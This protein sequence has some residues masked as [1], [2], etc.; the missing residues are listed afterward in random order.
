MSDASQSPVACGDLANKPFAH[1]VLYLYQRRS[2]GTLIV[3]SRGA[4][5]R[6]LFH[7]GQAVAA[8]V[9]Q[10]L[11]AL[12][13]SLLPLAELESAAFEFHAADLV[14]SGAD[15]VTGMFDPLAFAVRA[16]RIHA[17]EDI[18]VG[19]LS[20]YGSALLMLDPALNVG[21]L[22]L[23]AEELPF[24]HAC[25]AGPQ[26]CEALLR[27]AGMPAEEARRLLYSF[28]ITGALRP[29]SQSKRPSGS[30]PASSTPSSRSGPRRIESSVSTRPPGTRTSGDAWRAIASA[31][32]AMAEGRASDPGMG[33]PRGSGSA[34]PAPSKRVSTSL[35]PPRGASRSLS[36]PLPTNAHPRTAGPSSRPVSRPLSEPLPE[37]PMAARITESRPLSTR[38]RTSG[39]PRA[40]PSTP[41]RLTPRPS[42]SDLEGLD[43]SGKLQRIELL[44]QRNAF[45]EALP[46][47]RELLEEDRRNPKY[48][49]LLAHVLYGRV[50]DTNWGKELVDCVNMALRSDPDEPYALFTKARCYKRMGR[51][52]EAL[53]YFRRLLA[54]D[55][56]HMEAAREARLLASRLSDRRKK[57]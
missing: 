12:D 46:Y 26:S 18:V 13:D 29:E 20:K 54:I 44:C 25:R 53:H 23:T 31:A 34:K 43:A 57:G 24:L 3:R 4:E 52:R 30:L 2:S 19:V 17:R 38:E 27:Q 1:L 40:R 39:L 48:L 9:P 37:T 33:S 10:P 21:R 49:G 35:S 8:R 6:T 56:D 11:A 14:G 41:A 7:R 42:L 15:V 32:A 28:L 55:P 16:A 22:A 45:H 5:Y 51:E 36:Q 47:M 50:S